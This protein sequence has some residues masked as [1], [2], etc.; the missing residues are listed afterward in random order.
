MQVMP[1]RQAD[2]S[3]HIEPDG[4]E[5]HAVPADIL[6][7]ILEHA[8]RA[9]Q[10]IGL[11]VEGRGIK[12]RARIARSTSSRF[13]LIC[14]LPQAGSYA[15]PLEVGARTELYDEQMA[16]S[17][18]AIFEELMRRISSKDASDLAGVLP[19]QSILRRVL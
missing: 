15:V 18:T 19:D 13:Q 12:Q 7:Q 9:F 8:Q 1:A 10:L 17:A 11:H 6:V 3:F 14:K 16:R 5:A 4:P 2:L